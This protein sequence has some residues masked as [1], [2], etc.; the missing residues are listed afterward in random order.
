VDTD[1][2]SADNDVLFNPSAPAILNQSVSAADARLKATNSN[3]D[4][5]TQT[6]TL[7]TSN[8]I[9]NYFPVSNGNRSNNND[10]STGSLNPSGSASSSSSGTS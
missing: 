6:G 8:F 10:G 7:Q 9:S 2:Y 5:T 1:L 4:N 3:T